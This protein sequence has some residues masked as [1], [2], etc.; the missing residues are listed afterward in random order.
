MFLLQ[1]QRQ[2]LYTLVPGMFIDHRVP[3]FRIR[4]LDHAKKRETRGSVSFRSSATWSEVSIL[5]IGNKT[6]KKEEHRKPIVKYIYFTLHS[7]SSL[8]CQFK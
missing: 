1:R 7:S 3:S 8:K 2:Q 4:R 6:I 5:N